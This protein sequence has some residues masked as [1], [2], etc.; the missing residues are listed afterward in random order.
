[1]PLSHDLKQGRLHLG[2]RTVDLVGQQEV[3]HHRAELGV[4]LFLALAVDAST[5]D[6]G[7]HQVGGEL[8][9][10]EGP[11]H[12]LG[13]SLDRKCLGNTGHTFEQHVPLGEQTDQNSLDEPVLTHDDALDLKDGAL[14]VLHL[15]GQGR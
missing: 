8:N 14:E 2:G 13:E 6:V 3:G 10:G 1:M 4:E 15:G 9:T 11:A 5:D 12:H 7:R